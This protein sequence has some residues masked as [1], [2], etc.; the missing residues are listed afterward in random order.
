ML[1]RL[2][3]RRPARRVAL[4]DAD[5]AQGVEAA[6]LPKIGPRLRGATVGD[7]TFG[8]VAEG[9][10]RQEVKDSE[11]D[12]NSKHGGGPSS[13]VFGSEG[14]DKTPRALKPTPGASAEVTR[15]RYSSGRNA[16]IGENR[17]ALA[18]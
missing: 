9:V 10:R 13:L 14:E 4:R 16:K 7:T 2:P 5:G 15:L 8:L 1:R 6:P 11:A 3:S 12:A 17:A 18:S